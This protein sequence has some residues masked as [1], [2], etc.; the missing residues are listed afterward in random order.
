MRRLRMDL[1]RRTGPS[2]VGFISSSLGRLDG[3]GSEKDVSERPGSPAETNGLQP[4]I[5]LNA[6]Q[7]ALMKI[8][9]LCCPGSFRYAF[10]LLLH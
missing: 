5:A 1:L 3:G 6:A 7:Q 9:H 8:T 10:N 2:L 4:E